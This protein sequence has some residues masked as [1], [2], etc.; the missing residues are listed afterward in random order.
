MADTLSV[1]LGP[2]VDIFIIDGLKSVFRWHD[3]L[4]NFFVP[5]IGLESVTLH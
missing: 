4:I 2:K 3:H 5:N 1:S